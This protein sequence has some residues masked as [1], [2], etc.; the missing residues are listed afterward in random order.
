MHRDLKPGN[1]MLTKSG[2]KLMD[3]GLAKPS[4]M[5][6]AASGSSPILVSAMQTV[7]AHSPMSPLTTAGSVVGTIQ[8]MSPEQ[9]EGREVDVRSDIFALGALLY[10]MATGKPAFAGKSQVT[11]AS[12]ILE[13]DPPPVSSVNPVSPPA[14]DY[15]ITTCL[16]K[17]REQRFQSARDVCLQLRWIGDGSGSST[18]Q[19]EGKGSSS[20]LAWVAAGVLA[21][22]AVVAAVAYFRL[23]SACRGTAVVN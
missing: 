14:L 4:A 21:L 7:D 2:A 3:F 5:G 13:K 1:V 12:A 17:D 10:E 22:L 6:A 8:Y 16:A 11:V 20:R 15:L 18:A 23:V 19:P 9:L